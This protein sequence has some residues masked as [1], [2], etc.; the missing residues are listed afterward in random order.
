MIHNVNVFELRNR[1]SKKQTNFDFNL[2]FDKKD[3]ILKQKLSKKLK[4]FLIKKYTSNQS[5]TSP[6]QKSSHRKKHGLRL[7]N[8]IKN[9][10]NRD[11]KKKKS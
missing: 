2:Y 9:S 11:L 3:G 8:I 6:M 5:N 7:F 1:I 4:K 10:F